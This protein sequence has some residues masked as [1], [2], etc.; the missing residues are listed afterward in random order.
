[1]N[2]ERSRVLIVDD[3]SFNIT[4]LGEALSD[5]FEVSVATNGEDAL[6]AVSGPAPPDLVLLDIIM[7]GID[8]HE[9]CRRLKN[10]PSTA[11]IP[12]IFITS[13]SEEDDETKGLEL[14]AVDYI[15]KPFSIPIV[16]A[17]VRSHVE[18]KRQRDILR[19]LSALDGLT[20]IPNRRRF[21]EFLNMEWLRSR[22]SQS[23][24]S[25]IM[26]DID[27]FKAYNDNYGHAEGDEC[28]RQVAR[29]L[30]FCIKRPS[31]LIARY[32]GEEF[33]AILAETETD[34]AEHLAEDIRNAVESLN[35]PHAHSLVTD[36]VTI[37]VGVATLV[38]G[39]LKDPE[40]LIK[41]ADAMLYEAK[42]N[43]RNQ[44]RISR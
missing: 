34:G 3:S 31:D 30:K 7:P 39:A 37:S 11:S 21:D 9:V 16:K 27:H 18:L 35:I 14:G 15:T 10:N 33:A 36:H 2:S 5:E 13:M 8:G 38:P 44:V 22:R 40:F 20:G 12:V 24:V 28:L 42:E 41:K 43:G 17:R 25:L 4:I 29:A 26:A 19:D 6:A 32:G 1:M 23:P